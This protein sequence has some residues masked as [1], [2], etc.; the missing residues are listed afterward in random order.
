MKC[1]N[2]MKTFALMIVSGSVYCL[3]GN[4]TSQVLNGNLLN[5]D[6]SFALFIIGLVLGVFTARELDWID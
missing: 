1:G 5:G 6:N 4:V 2:V 3:L